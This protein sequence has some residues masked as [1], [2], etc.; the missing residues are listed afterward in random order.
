MTSH[1]ADQSEFILSQGSLRLDTLVRLRWLA[2]A[3]QTAAVL[4]VHFGLGFPLPFVPV[5]R[6]HR[7]LGLAQPRAPA[8]L[9]GERRGS[10]TRR[11]PAARLRLLQLAGLL[12][13][14]GGLQNPFAILFLAP[15]LI[16]ATALPPRIDRSRSACSR[17]C[18]ATV[19]AFV[20][21]PLPW[22]R[23]RPLQLPC[24]LRRRRLDGAPARRSP[25]P[26]S[27]PGGSPRRRAS[28]PRRSPRPSWCSPASST[29]R[30]STAS[31][32][33]PP[34][35]SARRSPPSPWSPRSSSARCRR[36]ARSREDLELLREQVERCRDIL[37]K[38]AVARRAAA[39]RSTACR[40]RPDRGGGRAAAA[41]SASP[42]TARPAGRRAGAGRR[43]QSR[44]SSTA[45]ATSSRTPSTSPRAGSRSRRAGTIDEVAID[46]RRR[47]AGLCARDPATRLGEPYVTSRGGPRRGGAEPRGRRPRPRLLHRQDAARALRRPAGAR[48]RAAA[49]ER[50][51]W[52]ASP[53]RARP[54]EASSAT[55]RRSL[56]R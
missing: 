20:H 23:A 11:R 13:L 31:P 29:C 43:P 52:C 3:G 17:S 10:A 55:E 47:R 34:T 48:Q 33:R 1:I 8:A 21:L 53:G 9:P 42:S 27:M 46:D 39:R 36:T 38:L 24:A 2:I 40:C 12:F 45:S 26:A 35:S 14:T 30:R 15:V 44:R 54:F 49:V 18:C 7:A 19:L 25:S 56:H 4:F 16:S 50:A 28:S 37:G 32:R 5:L 22:D 6:R 51:P 41:P